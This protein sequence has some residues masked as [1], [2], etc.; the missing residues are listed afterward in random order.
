MPGLGTG[1]PPYPVGAG[2][3]HPAADPSRAIANPLPSPLDPC[4]NVN[5]NKETQQ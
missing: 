5:Y 4:T 3:C 1:G 2:R